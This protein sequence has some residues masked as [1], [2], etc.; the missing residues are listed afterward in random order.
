[1]TTGFQPNAFQANAFQVDPVT[2]V[3]YAVD[4]NDTCL[5]RGTIT[6]GADTHDGFTRKEIKHLAAIKKKLEKARE[7][8]DKVFADANKRRK[9]TLKNVIDPKPVA[10]V[11]QIEVESKE[12]VASPSIDRVSLAKEIER[13]ELQQALLQKQIAQKEAKAQYDAYMAILKAQYEAE[14]EDEEAILMLL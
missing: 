3:L 14:L 2:G 1:M 7:L 12:L 8:Q 5:I 6:S 4:Q 10:K 11:K 9:E 13:L